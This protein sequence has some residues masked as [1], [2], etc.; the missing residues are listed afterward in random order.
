VTAVDSH[1]QALRAGSS[2]LV[3]ALG[4]LIAAHALPALLGAVAQTPPEWL[5]RTAALLGLVGSVAMLLALVQ[6][7]LARVGGRRHPAL[8]L[9]LVAWATELGARVAPLNDAAAQIEVWSGVQLVASSCAMWFAANG[10]LWILR[11]Q[12]A[13]GVLAPWKRVRIGFT[14][15]TLSAASVLI[16][17][18]MQGPDRAIAD[19]LASIPFGGA[20]AW[21]VFALPWAL[22]VLAARASVRWL[23]RVRSTAE[24]LAR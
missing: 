13:V 4:P 10:V 16:S 22:L 7:A 17:A 11:A 2:W 14:V 3:L 15:L 23:G 19:G 6:L 20:L 24:I 21:L 8:M 9:A 12:Q 1:R 18:R 5:A